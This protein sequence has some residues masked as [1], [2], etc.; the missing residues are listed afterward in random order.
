MSEPVGS[1]LYDAVKNGRV[2]EVSAL[3]RDHPGVNVNWTNTLQ[4]TP[5]HVASS[6]GSVEGVKLLLAHP[7]I[8][9]NLKEVF[10]Q[11]PLSLCCWNNHVSVIR[12]LL[13]DSSN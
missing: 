4:W 5:L 12:L 8:N 2:S 13:K 3:L 1:Q 6:Y 7:D 11:T 9:V 10:G